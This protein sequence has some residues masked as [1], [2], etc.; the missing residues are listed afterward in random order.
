[1]IQF[2]RYGANGNNYEGTFN[3][4]FLLPDVNKATF[5]D[6]SFYFNSGNQRFQDGGTGG[7]TIH[8]S[9]SSEVALTFQLWDRSNRIKNV[10]LLAPQA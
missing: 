3:L 9:S 4:N 5:I 8:R 6:S 2:D 7:I 1:M 10:K